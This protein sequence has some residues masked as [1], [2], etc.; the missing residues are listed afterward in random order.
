MKQIKN[1]KDSFMRKW[2]KILHWFI[3]FIFV[4]EI[5]YGLYM[6]F[7][8][9]GGSRWPL[10]GRAIETPIEVIL[11][12]RLYAIETWITI[13]GL[14]IYLA[15]MTVFLPTII[16]SFNKNNPLVTFNPND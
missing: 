13:A 3:I 16:R 14:A 12:R 4:L 11:K 10:M 2:M 5:G 7:F 6:G 9:V 15:A 1:G 8:A